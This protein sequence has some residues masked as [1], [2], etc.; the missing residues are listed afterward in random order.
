MYISQLAWTDSGA[1]AEERPSVG[2]TQE[3]RSGSRSR[4]E[5]G[6]VEG[7]VEG[8]VEGAGERAGSGSGS[9]AGADAKPVLLLH[10]FH[11]SPL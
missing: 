10:I 5:A 8:G 11:H 3:H 1:E 2:T 6:A 9:G 7:E 4:T